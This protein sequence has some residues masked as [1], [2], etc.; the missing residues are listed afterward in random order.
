MF[1]LFR[2]HEGDRDSVTV[3][4]SLRKEVGCDPVRVRRFVSDDSF[5]RLSDE[6]A[7]QRWI[8]NRLYLNNVT[9]I[10]AYR[11]D[12]KNHVAFRDV[13]VTLGGCGG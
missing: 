8:Y 13:K 9:A 3:V 12:G 6:L 10:D 11:A 7:K 5:A 1:H 2:W 4:F